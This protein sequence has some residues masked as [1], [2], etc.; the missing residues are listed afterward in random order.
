[1]MDANYDDWITTYIMGPTTF[2]SCK[3]LNKNADLVGRMSNG[4]NPKYQIMANS[5]Q[6]TWPSE[7]TAVPLVI[8]IGPVVW[9]RW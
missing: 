8:H 2:I 4:L 5:A 7:S 1:M 3:N 6:P 9:C